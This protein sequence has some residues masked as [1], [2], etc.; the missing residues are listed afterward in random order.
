[1]MMALILMLGAIALVI[2]MADI[3]P[4]PQDA[5]LLLTD[6]ITK[7]ASFDTP[8]LDLGANRAYSPPLPVRVVVSTSALGT[9]GNQSYTF[10][11]QE[12]ADG[13]TGWAAA[14][15]GVAVTANGVIMIPASI[16]KRYQ[17][18]TLQISGAGTTITFTAWVNPL[19]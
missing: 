1:M 16:T 4:V 3:T 17:K 5:Q 15:A 12:S 6:T 9:G 19:R 18:L 7:T 2:L 13:S 14:S 10:T 11:L 8:A